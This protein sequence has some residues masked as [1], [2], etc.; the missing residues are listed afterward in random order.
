MHVRHRYN[1]AVAA[2]RAPA[3]A[4]RRHKRYLE[5]AASASFR[6]IHSAEYVFVRAGLHIG[7][8]KRQHHYRQTDRSP[9]SLT[10]AQRWRR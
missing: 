3:L 4:A 5:D 2:T 10:I 9:L 1:A 7:D 6:D 8:N